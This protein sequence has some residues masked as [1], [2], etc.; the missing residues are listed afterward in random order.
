MSETLDKS[1]LV[2]RP[3]SITFPPWYGELG[4]EIMT[5]VPMLRR[6]AR[7]HDQVVATSFAGMGPLYADF[8]TE[9]C[10]HG[11]PNRSLDYPKRYRIE[12]D[13]IRY[14]DAA[15]ALAP[16]D[17]LIHARGIGRKSSINYRRWREL[18]DLLHRRPWS[19]GWIGSSNDQVVP[20]CGFDLRGRPL[21]SLM[22]L[23]AASRGVV[24]VSSG[25]MHLAAA[26]GRD[27][28]VWG[29]TK[30]R[31][32]ETL[33]QRY[34]LTWNPHNVAVGWIDADDWQPEPSRIMEEIE[35]ML[36]RKNHE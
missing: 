14:G 19:I 36:E 24:G 25:V 29:D 16:F 20:G 23:I 33:E 8:A 12:G 31:Y 22:D 10:T 34:K 7:G 21:Q 1:S 3:S 26:C 30:T 5:W 9:F 15:R 17:L 11:Q 18:V 13:H 32:W 2:P 35:S 6:Q 27:L 4:W 28:V